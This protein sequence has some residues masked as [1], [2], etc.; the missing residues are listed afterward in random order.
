M[1]DGLDASLSDAT[2]R[3][4]LEARSSRIDAGRR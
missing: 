1:H 3:D 2:V 4:L